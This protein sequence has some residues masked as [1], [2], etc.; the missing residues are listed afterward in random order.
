MSP[1]FPI[2]FQ[3]HYMDMS[4]YAKLVAL[5]ATTATILGL[6]EA[7]YV[8]N[9]TYDYVSTHHAS[10]LYLELLGTQR[11]RLYLPLDYTDTNFLAA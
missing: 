6:G 7:Q 2:N 3:R 10:P 9:N 1:V 4:A 11:S 8:G 5:L